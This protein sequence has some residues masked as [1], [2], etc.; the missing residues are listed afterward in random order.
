M[1]E[2]PRP[3]ASG[4][5]GLLSPLETSSNFLLALLGALGAL[6]ALG[7][8]AC[9]GLVRAGPSGPHSG[10]ECLPRSSRFSSTVPS[11]TEAVRG[12]PASPPAVSSLGN[13]SSEETPGEQ[14]T[15][16]AADDSHLRV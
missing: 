9:W 10:W 3:R 12:Q 16:S 1:A 11:V 5:V 14:K 2:R 15:H 13:G 7:L 6:G 8:Q 4:P